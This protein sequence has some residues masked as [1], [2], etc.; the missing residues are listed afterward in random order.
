MR[1][2]LRLMI[3]EDN[4]DTADS[5]AI[6]LSYWGID[7]RVCRDGAEALEAAPNYRPDVALIDLMMPGMDGYELASRLR[8][9]DDF[10]NLLLI[11]ITGLGDEA[12]RRLAQEAGFAHHLLKPWVYQQ[13]REILAAV[14][15]NHEGSLKA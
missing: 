15:Q 10:K 3:V 8:E 13:L 6:L 7:A 4:K 9:H 5:L 14:M 1:R 2:P 12:N 11:A